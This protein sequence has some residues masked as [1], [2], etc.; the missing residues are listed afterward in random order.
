[1][2]P[3]DFTVTPPAPPASPPPY[4]GPAPAPGGNTAFEGGEAC[5]SFMSSIT[6]VSSGPSS[7]NSVVTANTTFSVWTP[8]GR[9]PDGLKLCVVE[10]GNTG[11]GDVPPGIKAL[12]S[13]DEGPFVRLGA[14]GPMDQSHYYY[15][16][17]SEPGPA[18][19]QVT[20]V[21]KHLIVYRP[22]NGKWTRTV[23]DAA[24]SR[25]YATGTIDRVLPISRSRMAAG[26]MYVSV[27]RTNEPSVIWNTMD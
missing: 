19:Q 14:V 20:A 2:V 12:A 21:F 18:Y 17:F 11:F 6:V 26:Q 10:K 16:N 24:Q 15:L 7:R 3:Y 25:S 27:L 23:V 8:T 4:T 5:P 13:P 9:G 1:V 22:V